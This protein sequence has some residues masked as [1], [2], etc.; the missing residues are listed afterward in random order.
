MQHGAH[1]FGHIL[2]AIHG[3]KSKKLLRLFSNPLSL[4]L[5]DRTEFRSLTKTFPAWKNSFSSIRHSI[6]DSDFVAELVNQ[7]AYVRDQLAKALMI[8]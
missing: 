4:Q 3:C 1:F 8:D 5:S 2:S 7:P 6:N